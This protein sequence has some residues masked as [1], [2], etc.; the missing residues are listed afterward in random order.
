VHRLLGEQLQHGGADV[1]AVRATAAAVPTATEAG[2]LLAER[3]T[4]AVGVVRTALGGSIL[5]RT[6]LAERRTPAAERTAV[7]LPVEVT[8]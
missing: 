1:A 5:E 8:V 6:A 2:P 4:T 3:R 7:V